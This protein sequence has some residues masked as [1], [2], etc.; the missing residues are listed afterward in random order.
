MSEAALGEGLDLVQA[1]RVRDRRCLTA[2]GDRDFGARAGDAVE[3]PSPVVPSR[4]ARRI[5]RLIDQHPDV[6]ER[7]D[8]LGVTTERELDLRLLDDRVDPAE[9]IRRRVRHRGKSLEGVLEERERLGV[10]PAALRLF[11]GQDGIVDGFPKVI[12]QAYGSA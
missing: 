3:K 7:M 4:T 6:L 5:S 1:G 9:P 2:I 11:C 12:G 8:V 10:G